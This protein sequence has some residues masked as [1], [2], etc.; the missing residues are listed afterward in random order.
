MGHK[1]AVEELDLAE[2]TL[3]LGD[4]SGIRAGDALRMPWPRADAIVGNPPF[5]GSQNIRREL[6]DDYAEWLRGAFG[7]GLKDYCVYW[8]RRAHEQLEPG[9]RAGLVGTNSVS[10]NRARGASLDYIAKQGGT[11][12]DAVSKQKWPEEAVVNVSI[13]N[14]VK[15]PESAPERFLLA[16]TEVEGINTRLEA[17][18]DPLVASTRLEAN[19]GRAFQGP[20]PVGRGVLLSPEEAETLL[21]RAD[22]PYRDV[23][24][25]FLVSD[26]IAEDPMQAASRYVIDFGLR[27]LEEAMRYPAA[28]DILRDRVKDERESNRDRFR[29]EHWW[30][31]GRPVLSMRRALAPSGATSREPESASAHCSAGATRGFA[32]A[33]RPTFSLSRVT[34]PLGSSPRASTWRGPSE[35]HRRCV[36]TPATP[37]PRRLRPSPGQSPRPTTARPS[38]T[39]PADVRAPLRDLH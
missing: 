30:L 37:R 4:L 1:L 2:A 17:S 6:G 19:R 27:P 35:S 31:L 39:S 11:I 36:S 29:R 13:V 15:E 32:R 8:F 9:R 3:P 34:T 16:G 10:Q 25:P 23:V 18:A 20:M 21:S 14:W 5:H 12:T 22:A 33:T 7:V 28:L 26:D 24:R 38:P